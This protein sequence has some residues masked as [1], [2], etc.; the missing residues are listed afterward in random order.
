MDCPRCGLINPETAQRCDCGYDFREGIVKKPY[1]EQKLPKVIRIYPFVI[2]LLFL[3]IVVNALL[4]KDLSVLPGLIIW[5]AISS[6]LYVQLKKGKN[7]ARIALT[8]LT[9]PAGLV[10]GISEEAKLYC[11]QKGQ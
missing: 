2:A 3:L 4:N 6:F 9:F 7:W 5:A 1:F 11:L 10:L 8:I